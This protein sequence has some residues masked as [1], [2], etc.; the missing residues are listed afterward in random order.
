MGQAPF[1]APQMTGQ[2][3]FGQAQPAFGQQPF[4]QNQQPFGQGQPFTQPQQT[5][6]MQP[7]QTGFVQQPQPLQPQT[8]GS[9][10]FRQSMMLLNTTGTG[11]PP[12]AGAMSQPASPFG[13]AQPQILR[14]GSSPAFSATSP[15]KLVAQA[16]G[17]KNPFAP[18]PGTVSAKPQEPKG[19]SMAEMAW[20]KQFGQ[21]TQSGPAQA[22]PWGSAN[23]QQT[24]GN[25]S[26]A[27]SNGTGMGDVASAFN[28]DFSKPSS[29]P[30]DFMSQFGSLS[31]NTN[32]TGTG[33][34]AT[35][36][37]QFNSLSSNPTG[38]T[39]NTSGF[40]SPVKTG[41]SGGPLQPQ[42]TGFGG[43]A[44]KR[45]QP[46]SSFG[47]QLVSELPPIHEPGSNATSPNHVSP[48]VGN[49]NPQ[50]TGFPGLSSFSQP[51]TQG[52]N[53]QPAQLGQQ[54]LSPQQTGGP[55]PF[56]QS[57]FGLNS[58]N[59]GGPSQP[60]GSGGPFGPMGSNGQSGPFGGSSPFAGQNKPQG[61]PWQGAFGQQQ[62]QGGSLL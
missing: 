28:F 13:M 56:R 43:S 10:P 7:Q 1:L 42:T 21:Q 57:M 53:G 16:T 8:T 55:N 36:P 33:T 17:S 15:P 24:N 54:G 41:S 27:A 50:Q 61:Q 23:G 39:S 35:S 18:A 30:N 20:N 29:A 49:V 52:Q 19:M 38:F 12:H 6:F 58:N 4:G 14:P 32:T 62:Q 45:F 25:G 46:T 11:M 31:V 48:G 37:T 2:M 47:S 51:Q 9:N 59:T 60:F 26:Q 3:A 34:S 40:S 5:G 22:S 44:V